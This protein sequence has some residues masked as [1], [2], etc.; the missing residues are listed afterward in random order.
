[1]NLFKNRTFSLFVSGSIITIMGDAFLDFALALYI[2]KLTGSAS[3]FAFILTLAV[4][5]NI[6]LGPIAG[7]IVDRLDKK[8]I[9][10]GFDLIRGVVLVLFIALSSKGSLGITG[11]YIMAIIF[12]ICSVIYQPCVSTVIPHILEREDLV[13]GNMIY[14]TALQIG[15]IIAPMIAALIYHSKGIEFVIGIDAVTFFL[16]AF[17]ATLYKFKD[18]PNRK[19]NSVFSDIKSGITLFK[20]KQIFSL[21]LNGMFSYVFVLPLFTVG[22]PFIIKNIFNGSDQNY[23]VVQTAISIASVSMVLTIPRINKKMNE[24]KALN[25]SMS[26]MLLGI[27]SMLLLANGTIFSYL[28]ENNLMM[29]VFLVV[30]SFVFYLSFANYGVFY[31]TISQKKVNSEFL[32]RYNSML[33]M[34][35]AI[36]SILGNFIFG[37]LYDTKIITYAVIV[38]IVGMIIKFALNT[39]VKPIEEPVSELSLNSD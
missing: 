24:I 16:M 39:L 28:K 22:M 20:D 32:G 11:I 29:V 9:L 2:L 30:V 4:I 31:L 25:F 5:P 8:K 17:I 6:V 14:R 13:K 1:M 23:S 35:F 26:G 38:G 27:A 3:K 34:M 21:A 18:I 37:Y 15:Q 19:R 12:G 7:V 33:L 10:V 36:G